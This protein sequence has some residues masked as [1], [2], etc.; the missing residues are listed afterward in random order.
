[1]GIG[2]LYAK[3]EIYLANGADLYKVKRFVYYSLEVLLRNWEV[4]I[5]YS[6]QVF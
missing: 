6:R 2:I 5:I 4:R 3:G 1:M